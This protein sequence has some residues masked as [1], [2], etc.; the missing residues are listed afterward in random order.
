MEAVRGLE[1]LD[2]SDVGENTGCFPDTQII[3]SIPE[4]LANAIKQP[5]SGRQAA[6]KTKR[7]Q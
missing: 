1:S 6:A 7:F 4:R 2:Q 3:C 5:K